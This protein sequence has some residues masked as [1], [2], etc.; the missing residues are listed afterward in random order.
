MEPA[1]WT[2]TESGICVPHLA[3]TP[4]ITYSLV[5]AD[6]GLPKLLKL[7]FRHPRHQFAVRG[8]WIINWSV[9]ALHP[10][11]LHLLINQPGHPAI[12]IR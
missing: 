11:P 3:T 5:I 6:T 7:L 2:Q 4:E 9:S 10:R 12:P 8:S 1:R